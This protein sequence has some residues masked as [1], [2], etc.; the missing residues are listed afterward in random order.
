M[1][2]NEYKGRGRK[3]S[4]PHRSRRGGW[5]YRLFMRWFSLGRLRP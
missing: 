1:I 4:V 3:A 5:F 2:V